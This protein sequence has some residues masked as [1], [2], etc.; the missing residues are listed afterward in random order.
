MTTIGFENHDHDSCIR[1]GIQAAEAYCAEE[2][3]HFT[4]IRRRVLELLLKGHRALGAYEILEMLRKEG[5]NAQPPVAYRALDFLVS[6]GFAHKIERQNAFIACAH[7]G[8]THTPLFLICR[9]CEAVAETRAD[10][11]PGILARAADE[12]GFTTET[13]VMEAFGLCAHCKTGR[14]E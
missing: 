3:L 1:D 5:H 9:S 10:T 2:K 13:A 7:P 11:A 4:P 6:N 12:A 14:A 8:R